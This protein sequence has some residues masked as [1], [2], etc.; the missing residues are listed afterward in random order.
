MAH[1]RAALSAFDPS[2]Y[3]E[4]DVESSRHTGPPLPI[5]IFKAFEDSL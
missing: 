1:Q 3:D 4:E 2:D 5:I